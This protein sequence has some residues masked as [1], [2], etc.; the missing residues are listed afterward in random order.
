MNISIAIATYNRSRELDLTLSSLERVDFSGGGEFEILVIDNNSTDDTSGVAERFSSG[1]GGRLRYIREVRQGL[2]H[3][4]NRAIA[5][6]QYEIVAFLDDDVDVNVTWFQNLA[7]VYR[8]GNYAA[9]G[10]RAFLV[11][12]K[13]RPAWLGERDEGLL[14]KVELGPDRRAAEPDELYGVNVSMRKEW[15]GRVGG[16]RT[17]LGR[18]GNRLWGSEET[19]L[20]ARV[21]EAGGELLYE[22]TAVVGHRVPSERLRRAWFWSRCYWGLQSEARILRDSEVT[23][24]ALARAG[25]WSLLACGGTVRAAVS[26]GPR[27]EEF[28]HHSKVLAGRCGFLLGLSGR[29]LQRRSLQDAISARAARFRQERTPTMPNTGSPNDLKIST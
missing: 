22:P 13:A 20:L 18:V 7:A 5:E 11:Y 19:E 17:D 4:R 21:V 29:F 8:E 12:P 2:S 26:N 14:T 16:F 27:S 10:G 9:V 1:F 23:F 24:Y 3:A 25:W 15:V 28:F 6:S